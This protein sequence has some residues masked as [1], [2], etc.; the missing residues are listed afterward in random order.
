MKRTIHIVFIGDKIS[1]TKKYAF[2]CSN[3]DV[4]VGDIIR[5]PRYT[6]DML[7]VEIDPCD[8][9]IQGG[10]IIKNIRI[11]LLNGKCCQDNDPN[12]NKQNNMNTEQ[13]RNIEITLE[14]AIDWYN[15][16]DETLKTL[17]L[18]A[19][20]KEE[21]ELNLTYIKR[22]AFT[23]TLPV[24]MPVSE[25][26]KFKTLADLEIIAKHFNGNWKKDNYNTGYFIGSYVRDNHTA[27]S[28]N[29]VNIYQSTDMYSGTTYFKNREDVT[30]AIDILGDRIKELFQ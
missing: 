16:N 23:I 20:R 4:K 6:P 12:T 30:K 1:S 24:S 21:L 11:K 14:Q 28:Y 19:Y 2:L 15:S 17:A 9:R 13:K 5:D 10:H 22:K 18:T 7:V 29:G 25:I 8:S 26:G 3:N 27:N